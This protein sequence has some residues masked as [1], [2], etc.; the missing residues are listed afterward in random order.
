MSLYLTAE[1]KFRVS[2]LIKLSV[3]VLLGLIA[4]ILMTDPA[5]ATTV[6]SGGVT[7]AQTRVNTVMQGWQGIVQG[8]GVA[9]L[10]VAWSIIGYQIAFNGKSMKDMLNPAL[11]S[12]IAGLAPVLVGW[13]FS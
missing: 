4:F 13:M 9:I 7:A 2:D 6:G 3:F 1:N 8:V 12:T 11:G 5:F 10:V